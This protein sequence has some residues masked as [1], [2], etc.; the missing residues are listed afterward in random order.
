M[1]SG[2]DV[3][4][5]IQPAAVN[6]LPYSAY[7]NDRDREADKPFADCTALDR[8]LEESHLLG[9]LRWCARTAPISGSGLDLAAGTLWATPHLLRAGASHVTAVEYSAHRLLEIGPRT[10]A[11]YA[12]PAGAVTLVVGTFD[13]LRLDDASCDFALLAQAFHHAERPDRL[14]DELRRVLRAGA[15]VWIIGEPRKPWV[16]GYLSYVRRHGRLFPSGDEVFPPDP[17]LG[18]HYY[19]W[20]AYRRLF[21]S[22]GFD[23]V[24]SH[25]LR[26]HRTFVLRRR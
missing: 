15:P 19:T 14:L 5:W 9:E 3:R 8:F 18:D 24:S 12:V 11:H 2:Y 13:D 22:S 16:R 25:D 17:V 26:E 7:W 21:E 23:L 10:L 1:H 20:P 4:Y 6:E